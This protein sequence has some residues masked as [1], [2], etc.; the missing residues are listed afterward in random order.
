M[1]ASTIASRPVSHAFELFHPFS[2][3]CL[4]CAPALQHQSN[5]RKTVLPG[6]PLRK[7]AE[8]PSSGPQCLTVLHGLAID[9]LGGSLT[10]ADAGQTCPA[11]AVCMTAIPLAPSNRTSAPRAFACLSW[12]RE[13]FRDGMGSCKGSGGTSFKKVFSLEGLVQVC[14]LSCLRIATS[15]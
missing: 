6:C 3:C 12:H 15:L 10:V 5:S 8:R 4:R 7:G 13:T 11:Q 1:G 14:Q 2:K 9:T